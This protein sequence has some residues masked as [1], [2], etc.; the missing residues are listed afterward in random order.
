MP[1]KNG[2]PIANKIGLADSYLR[3]NF[4]TIKLIDYQNQRSKLETATHPFASVIL[5]QAAIEIS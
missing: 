4:L 2:V 1:I 5:M 3:T